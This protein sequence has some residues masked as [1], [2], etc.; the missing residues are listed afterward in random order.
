MSTSSLLHTRLIGQDLF[1]NIV[2]MSNEMELSSKIRTIIPTILSHL[3]DLDHI[4][5]NVSPTYSGLSPTTYT[6]FIV[7]IHY[8]SHFNIHFNENIHFSVDLSRYITDPNYYYPNRYTLDINPI[9]NNNQLLNEQKTFEFIF[10]DTIHTHKKEILLKWIE[11]KLFDFIYEHR[12]HPQFG[13]PFFNY[14]SNLIINEKY[15]QNIYPD[16][17]F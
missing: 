11:D 15:L 12:N 8:N 3:D 1:K 5:K 17:P 9:I 4:V 6:Y 10:D 16:L 2:K 13:I 14:L 7:L